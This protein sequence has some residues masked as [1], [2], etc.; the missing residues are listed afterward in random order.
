MSF[1]RSRATHLSLLALSIALFTGGAHVIFSRLID[2]QNTKQLRELNELVLRRAELAV[3]YAFIALGE[4]VEK[5]TASCDQAATSDLRRQV[6]QRS[7]IKDIRVVDGSGRVICSAFPETLEF[8]AQ[9]VPAAGQIGGRNTNVQLFPL[10]QQSGVAL[11]VRWQVISELSLIAIVN[12]DAFLFDVLPDELREASAVFL[13]LSGGSTIASYSA[14]GSKGDAKPSLVGLSTES[15]RYPLISSIEIEAG[16]FG[17][18]NREPEGIVLGIGAILGALFGLLL[19]KIID[20]PPDSMA[21]LDGALARKEFKPFMQPIFSLTTGAIVGC[22]VLARWVRRDGSMVPPYRFIPLAEESGRIRLLTQHIVTDALQHLQPWLKRHKSFKV[23]INIAPNQLLSPGFVGE[24]K[25]LVSRAKVSARQI[26]IELT[27]RQEI[28]DLGRAA[29]VI[30]ELREHGFKVAI[31]DAGTGH[32]GLSYV[33]KLGVDTIK[34]DKLFVDSVGSDRSARVVVE[35]LVRVAA[36]LHM[37]TVAEGI[38]SEDQIAALQRCGVDEGQGYVVSPPITPEAFSALIE[39]RAA[40][41]AKLIPAFSPLRA[42][43][44]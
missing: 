7:I 37:T 10:P 33:Q 26:V 22:E 42:G 24:F 1:R 32:S 2:G 12:M 20:R 3:D 25:Q 39:N 38:E 40:T 41:E 36:E 16:A 28:E 11:G 18:W 14:G 31:D 43:A 17:R 23:G 15:E 4:L 5:G 27:E 19:R 34:I 21:E 13:K 44:A 35:M 30:A 8:D 29:A 9:S 6:Y